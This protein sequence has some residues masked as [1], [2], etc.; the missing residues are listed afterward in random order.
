MSGKRRM[1]AKKRLKAA[2]ELRKAQE[3]AEA[4]KEI[5]K[6]FEESVIEPEEPVKPVLTFKRKKDLLAMAEELGI[7]GLSSKNT[8]A[9]IIAAI[10]SAD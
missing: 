10:E 8:K 5:E 6:L 1:R 4:E 7:E 2:E 9:E 3:L